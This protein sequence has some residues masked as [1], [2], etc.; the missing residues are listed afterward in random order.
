MACHTSH[1][2]NSSAV[3]G[4]G[5]AKPKH[6]LGEV[7]P[8]IEDQKNRTLI[9]CFDGT[10]DQFDADNSNVVELVSLLKKDDRHRQLVYYQVCF[11]SDLIDA[12]GAYSF[13]IE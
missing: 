8:P 2:P 1:I 5:S 9:L 11:L 3:D 10:G 12:P 7:I 6:N 4:K 13:D